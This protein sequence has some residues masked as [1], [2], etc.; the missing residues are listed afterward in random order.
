M[1]K[2]KCLLLT[3]ACLLIGHVFLFGQKKS[4]QDKTG[5]EKSSAFFGKITPADFDL[6]T[7]KFDSG[8][9]AV[10][11][12]DI[13]SSDF[14][15]NNKGWFSLEFH[16]FK[17]IKILSKTG[18]EA[19]S[20]S[21]PLYSSGDNVEK[22]NNLKAVTYNLENG[23]VVEAKLE[24]KSIFTDKFSK[25]LVL[26]KFTF[27]AVK[28]GSIIEFSYTQT[29]DFL[30]NLQPW[31]FQGEYPCLWSEYQ[32]E[33]P[34]F[35]NYVF[36]GQGY[37]PFDISTASST[38]DS[39]RIVI[40]GGAERDEMANISA[41]VVGHRWAIK[42]IP[43]LKEESYT[44]TLKNHVAKIEFQLSQFR[45]P[46]MPVKDIMGNWH[47][48][49][50]ALLDDEDF[51]ADLA[52][53]N[54]WLTDDMKA[55][56]KG[57]STPLEKA[58]KIYAYVRDNF[59]CTSHNARILDNP[60]KTVFKN[61]NGNVAALN[62]L[63]AAMLKHENISIDPVLL[64]TRDNGF[65]HSIYP[66]IDRFNYVICRVKIDTMV[67]YL[68][69]SQTWL[70]FGHIPGYCYN[71]QARV[72]NKD[73]P[74]I[75][76]FNA[77]DA[78]EKK[79]TMVFIAN[80]EKGGLSGSY[81]SVPGYYESSQIRQKV[82]DKGEK[83]FFTNVQSVYSGGLQIS[84]PSI[85][86]VKLTSDPV[87]VS[88]DF[89]IPHDTTENIIYFNPLLATE[90]YKENPFKAAERIYPVEIPYAMDET[91]IL[92]MEVPA[93]YI[94][95]EAPKS[96]KVLLNTDEGFFEYIVQKDENNIQMRSRVKLLKADF[97]PDDYAVLRD[98]FAFV[99]KKQSEQFVFKKK[100]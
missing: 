9:E 32:V 11:I 82:H 78:T 50:E 63:L 74:E 36:L 8:A 79:T 35:L 3:G 62:L 100:K 23:K 64:S 70:G 52:R 13:G 14:V 92:N 76:Y 98:F 91:Y 97:K 29:S 90:V 87:K 37:V 46:D 22:L 93:G 72:I 40:P 55:V 48:T 2:K 20:V 95:E 81:Q 56:T 6:S 94:V 24:D 21:I 83:D 75:V 7:Q 60:L 89:V 45:F 68:D 61:K 65:A 26:K 69:A 31:E 19:A 4:G 10:I 12:A 42:N 88:Y 27:P 1:N 58:Q 30:F 34:D 18:F 49:S 15:G 44:T 16:H 86:S 38:H 59:T 67:F 71:G 28:E 51:G 80:D 54:G 43:A 5:Q 41:N 66:L 84:N 77:D 99:V 33:I 47:T 39:Y 53:N 57:A 25:H 73:F 96:T 17:R 85:D